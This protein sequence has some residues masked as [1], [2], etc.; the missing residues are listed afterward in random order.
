VFPTTAVDYLQ[1]FWALQNFKKLKSLSKDPRW[2]RLS[3]KYNLSLSDLE[4]EDLERI[5]EETGFGP[6]LDQLAEFLLSQSAD[7][8]LRDAVKFIDN[9]VVSV[10]D[11]LS[12]T[13]QSQEQIAIIES[14]LHRISS[15]L[16]KSLDK[17]RSQLKTVH[18]S[19]LPTIHSQFE[20]AMDTVKTIKMA[21]S[22]FGPEMAALANNRFLLPG[23]AKRRI[24]EL[25]NKSRSSFDAFLSLVIDSLVA[26]YMAALTD[27]Y[28]NLINA[29][30]A[31]FKKSISGLSATLEN[32]KSNRSLVPALTK[33]EV[34]AMGELDPASSQR[35]A[36]GAF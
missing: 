28:Q 9:V 20:S 12:M 3:K 25:Q 14:S 33:F 29:E 16:E 23:N 10:A 17:I 30:E 13:L 5:I 4:R 8:S 6:F 24:R 26:K 32:T 36:S 11:E 1:A 21:D 15:E 35:L 7:S 22:V 2:T 27:T 18:E 34:R 31:R 19:I